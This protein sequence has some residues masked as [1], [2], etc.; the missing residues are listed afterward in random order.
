MIRF[1]LLLLAL[2]PFQNC[3]QARALDDFLFRKSAPTAPPMI[4][5]LVVNER[6]GVVVEVKGKY[7]LYDPK[8][9][10]HI[11][12][13]FL[14]KRKYIQALKGG[15]QWGEEFPG[16]YQ[17][18]IVPDEQNI[19]VVV[20]GVEY[21]GSIY[22]YDIEG[23]ISVVNEVFIEDYLASLLAPQVRSIYPEEMLAAIAITA[24]TN[25]YYQVENP[26]NAYWDVD[27]K[28]IKYQG[29]SVTDGR[30]PIEQ[31]IDASRYLIMSRSPADTQKA[32]PIQAQWD[33][34]RPTGGEVVDA[35]ISLTEGEAMAKKGDHAAKIL[36]KAFPGTSILLMHYTSG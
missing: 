31:A 3:L 21:R 29:H 2:M 28:A 10:K 22:I 27:G 5:V 9:L 12:T 19:T 26:K 20:D 4:R 35:S 18:M 17:V 7:R 34:L 15:L 36:E 25:A 16:L 1:L 13:R 23:K 32:V 30:S 24:R 14:G 11:S 6:P 8:D 33:F